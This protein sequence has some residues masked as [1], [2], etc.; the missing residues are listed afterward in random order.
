MLRMVSRCR[1]SEEDTA[2]MECVLKPTPARCANGA[3]HFHRLK[4][5]LSNIPDNVSSLHKKNRIKY[6]LRLTS[7]ESW[8]ALA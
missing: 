2:N 3:G 7:T 6:I 5:S 8:N 4:S 1:Q